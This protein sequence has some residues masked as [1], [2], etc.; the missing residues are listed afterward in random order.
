MLFILIYF[1]QIGLLF[2]QTSCPSG[3]FGDISTRRCYL[4]VRDPPT[5]K[6]V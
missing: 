2:G 3:W 4:P 1:A 6:T 5:C